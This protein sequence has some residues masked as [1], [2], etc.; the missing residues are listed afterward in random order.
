[1]I[2]KVNPLILTLTS[3]YWIQSC[4]EYKVL[5]GLGELRA[6]AHSCNTETAIGQLEL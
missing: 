5:R 4:L 3:F 2:V 1:M 6:L